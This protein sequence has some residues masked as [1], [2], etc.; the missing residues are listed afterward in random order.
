M[1]PRH[2]HLTTSQWVVLSLSAI[3]CAVLG[4]SYHTRITNFETS[5]RAL[6]RT[7]SAGVS[8]EVAFILQ[9]RQRQVQLFAEDE[10]DH[11]RALQ[12]KPENDAL[13]MEIGRRLKRD[14]P[15]SFSYTIADGHGTPFITDFDGFVGDVCVQDIQ[16]FAARGVHTARIH[17]NAHVYHFD[18]MSRW[19]GADRAINLL[20]VSFEPGE[21]AQLLKS[22]EP[23]GHELILSLKGGT[24]TLEISAK[25]GRNATFRNDYRL[26]QEELSRILSRTDVPGS[27]WEVIDMVT[28]G[29]FAT[30]KQNVLLNLGMFLAALILV[31]GVSLMLLHREQQ[32]RKAAERAREDL[33]SVI[34]HE[35]RTPVTA[36]SGTLSLL[37]HG[38]MGDLPAPLKNNLE[39]L[40]RNSERLRHLIDDLLESRR[41]QS[42]QLTLQKTRANLKQIASDTILLLDDMATQMKVSIKLVE[43]EEDLWADVDPVRIQQVLSNLISNAA[44]YSPINSLVSVRVVRADAQTARVSVTDH[45]AGIPEAFWPQ[46]FEKFARGPAPKDREV[47]STGLGLNIVK[48]LVEAHNGSVGFS[49]KEGKGSIFYFTL[50]LSPSPAT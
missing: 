14:F 16:S 50:P 40:Q 12:A 33:V 36:I 17:P 21:L 29:L 43:A 45:G 11:L 22:I 6:A 7:A 46:V 1:Q 18:V 24:P 34:T 39:L 8:N 23:P 20:M 15:T 31:I 25:G 48:S 2:F 28:P 35:L 13:R 10:I 27:Q 42:T 37:A 9:E 44:K 5:H 4:W 49:S 19:Q 38:V 41:S 26:T 47:P 3:A 32:A 30:H